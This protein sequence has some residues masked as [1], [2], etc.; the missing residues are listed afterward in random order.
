M[1]DSM[2]ECCKGNGVCNIDCSREMEITQYDLQIIMCHHQE[3]ICR[4]QKTWYGS[5][6]YCKC[7]YHEKLINERK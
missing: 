6:K 4:L 3:I 7:P 1:G 2:H 5:T